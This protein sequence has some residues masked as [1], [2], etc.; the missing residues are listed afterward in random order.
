[1]VCPQLEIASLQDVPE[2]AY[3]GDGGEE[4]PVKR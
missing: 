4:F 1:V 2:M 3:G